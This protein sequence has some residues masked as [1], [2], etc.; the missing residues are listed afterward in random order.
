MVVAHPENDEPNSDGENGEIAQFT[1]EKPV[2]G[3]DGCEDATD[4]EPVRC[5]MKLWIGYTEAIRHKREVSAIGAGRFFE[6]T[7][8]STHPKVTMR[9]VWHGKRKVWRILQNVKRKSFTKQGAG[10]TDFSQRQ[11]VILA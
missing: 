5:L 3:E 9:A 8:L 1:F 11:G 2:N 10:R 4:A 6:F 7:L